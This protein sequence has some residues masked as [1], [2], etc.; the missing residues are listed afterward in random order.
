MLEKAVA[1][2]KADRVVVTEGRASMTSGAEILLRNVY[3]WF[4]LSAAIMPSRRKVRPLCRVGRRG[5]ALRH[6]SALRG[7]GLG[8]SQIDLAPCALRP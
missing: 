3:G 4:A 7:T 8:R 1:A 6:I 2:V 5:G